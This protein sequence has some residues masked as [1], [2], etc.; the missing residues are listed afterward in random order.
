MLNKI[1]IF[2][3]YTTSDGPRGDQDGTKSCHKIKTM[4][5]V[6]R[7]GSPSPMLNLKTPQHRQ[8]H[9]GGVGM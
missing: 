3:N 4:K 1:F 6:T 5:K 7:V 8:T 9:G 2:D